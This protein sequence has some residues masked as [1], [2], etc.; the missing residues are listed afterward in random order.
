MPLEPETD[1]HWTAFLYTS[2]DLPADEESAFETRLLDDQAARDAVADAVELAGALAVVGP[3]FRRRRPIGRRAFVAAS[4]LAAAAC[5]A[6]AIVPRLLPSRQDRPDASD[7]AIAWSS[8]RGGA[9]VGWMD[10]PT[11][12]PT[13]GPAQ[14]A[15]IDAEAEVEPSTDRALPSWLLTAASAPLDDNPRQ[16]D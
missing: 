1:L 3:D 2:G 9:E 16:E 13:A 8:L 7:V 15:E 11:G 10:L 4:V 14:V 12:S 6:V 5:L